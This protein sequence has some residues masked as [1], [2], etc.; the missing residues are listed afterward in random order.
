M[1][2]RTQTFRSRAKR[3]K[4][5]E[6]DESTASVSYCFESQTCPPSLQEYDD[7][8]EE[9]KAPEPAAPE[10]KKEEPKA[11]PA[12]TPAPAKAEP[13]K[14]PEP[15]KP[16]PAPVKKAPV[17]SKSQGPPS[18]TGRACCPVCVDSQLV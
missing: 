2:A 14:A 5:G 17:E 16:K 9:A 7:D 4:K 12:P 13:A 3:V 1:V 15:A 10:P 6:P 11:A 8:E 18:V